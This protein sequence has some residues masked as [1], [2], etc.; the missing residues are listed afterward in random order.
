MPIQILPARL[1]NQIAAGEVVER[2][3]SVIKELVENALDAG[4]TRIDIEVEKGG[5]KLI[6]IRDNGCGIAKD[7]LTLALS[8]HATSKVSSFDDLENITSLG[9]R[10]E[11]LAS[12]SSVSRLKLT[13]RPESQSEAWQAYAEGRD[14]A[15]KII[16][17]AHPQ[18]TTIEVVDL[19]F[20]TPA[21]RKFLRTEKTEFYHI[22]ELIKRIALSRFDV[23]ISLQHNGK[24]VRQFRRA[25]NPQ[26][27]AKRLGLICGRKFEQASVEIFCELD[28]VTINGWV[29][30]PHSCTA[31]S[32]VQYSYV[33]GRMMRDKLINHAIRQA[34]SQFIDGQLQAGFVLYLTVDPKQI[35][36]NVHPAKHEVRFHQARLIH[37]FIVHAIEQGLAEAIS[38]PMDNIDSMDDSLAEHNQGEYLSHQPYHPTPNQST[39]DLFSASYDNADVLAPKQPTHG[40]ENHVQQSAGRGYNASSNSSSN[41]NSSERQRP[42][43]YQ[44]Q[45]PSA[46]ELSAYHHALSHFSQSPDNVAEPNIEQ[47]N[48][49]SFHASYHGETNARQT[50]IQIPENTHKSSESYSVRPL[51]SEQHNTQIEN[52]VNQTVVQNNSKGLCLGVTNGHFALYQSEDRIF[53]LDL[54]QVNG[55]VAALQYCHGLVG[56]PLLLPVKLLKKQLDTQVS[57]PWLDNQK[58]WF[59]QLGI[60]Y[61][62]LKDAVVIRKVP[63]ILR[64]NDVSACV[65]RLFCLVKSALEKQGSIEKQSAEQ[66]N[67]PLELARIIELMYALFAKVESYD[68][69]EANKLI[70]KVIVSMSEQAILEQFAVKIDLASAMSELQAKSNDENIK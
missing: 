42:R 54:K 67:E 68:L 46:R 14:M 19:F 69:L 63:A 26:G 57:L 60:E 51:V 48:N 66:Q 62:C 43:Q 56:Q 65:G 9:F 58:D 40:V 38:P 8:R 30:L 70:A 31:Q 20:N 34:Y 22:D 32:D 12:I 11:A 3:A 27:K 59:A 53:L 49:D 45:N 64:Q 37:D 52:E 23:N 10:G 33:N 44:N 2:P 13:S 1:A 24:M 61:E 35:D 39:G 29:C 28:E 21:R 47:Q 16:P 36:V 25:E 50:G 7:E 6:R 18:G 4:A 41:L 55:K 17:A 5:S 15:V